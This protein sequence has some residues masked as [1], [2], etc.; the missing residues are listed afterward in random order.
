MKNKLLYIWYRY[1]G[2]FFRLLPIKNNRIAVQNFFGKGYGDNPKFI[3]EELLKDKK[4]KY[5]I[6]WF[7]KKQYYNNIP[8][9]IIQIKRGTLKELFYLY[10]SRIWI[11]NSRKHLGVTK[12]KN[13]FYIQ[14]WHGDIG[15]K[16]VEKDTIKPLSD[17]YIKTAKS[18]SKMIDIITSGSE[19]FTNKVKR[20]FWYT[21]EIKNTGSA[22]TDIFFKEK[23]ENLDFNIALYAPTFRD[24]GDISVYDLSFNKLLK[25]LNANSTKKWKIYV[26]F[27]PNA[28]NL[29]KNIDYTDDI[30]D[31]TKEEDMN[32]L[33]N[34][35]D[36]LITDYS[37]SMFDAIYA[38]KPVIL[39]IP[40]KDKYVAER[41]TYFSFDELPFIIT[42]D[43]EILYNKLINNE[44]LKTTE[45]Y[46][47]FLNKVN[48]YETGNSAKNI[49]YIIK[50]I[51]NAK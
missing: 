50:N 46:K 19:F 15:L 45:K 12:R 39:Y 31:G 29:Q 13:Q 27:H 1:V 18:D 51:I 22:R 25:S 34:N 17:Y 24:D 26:R 28:R 3:I 32:K 48:S 2:F 35:C 42:E 44:Y 16:R 38:N 11:D 49:C 23:K 43:K 6:I 8:K 33:I 36:L 30:I 7:V 20:A 5:E 10:T 9:S 4:E 47:K 40:D 21:G 37:S 41:G 14:T